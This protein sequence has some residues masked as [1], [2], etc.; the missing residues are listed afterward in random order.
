MKKEKRRK[1]G[2]KKKKD[3][4]KIEMFLK[5]IENLGKK[6]SAMNESYEEN[7]ENWMEQKK[8]RRKIGIITFLKRK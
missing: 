4:K 3:D 5:E 1:I 2:G 8:K 6:S 7:E